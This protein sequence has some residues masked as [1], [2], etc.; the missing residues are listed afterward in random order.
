VRVFSGCQLHQLACA[1]ESLALLLHSTRNR[2][3]APAQDFLPSAL[4]KLKTQN[5]THI[6]NR[7]YFETG[8][9]IF[10]ICFRVMQ[11]LPLVCIRQGTSFGSSRRTHTKESAHWGTRTRESAHRSRH[12]HTRSKIFWMCESQMQN[13]LDFDSLDQNHFHSTASNA[14]YILH[15]VQDHLHF[16]APDQNLLDLIGF[17]VVGSCR[18]PA[19]SLHPS[20]DRRPHSSFYCTRFL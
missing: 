18:F 15:F 9:T 19:A 6:W 2:T 17:P 11:D 14:K 13:L 20:P 3:P 5:W 16:D 4:C 1:V 7:K 8:S 10:C 12:T